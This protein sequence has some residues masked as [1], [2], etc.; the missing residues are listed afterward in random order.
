M[1]SLSNRWWKEI[2]YHEY[3]KSQVLNSIFI[4]VTLFPIVSAELF[5]LA[6]FGTRAVLQQQLLVMNVGSIC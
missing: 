2:Q 4:Y 1:R 5:C 6:L 3:P